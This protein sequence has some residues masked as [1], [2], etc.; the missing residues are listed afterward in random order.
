MKNIICRYIY[1]YY[2][3]NMSPLRINK[4]EWNKM[5]GMQNA[6][7]RWY[8]REMYYFLSYDQNFSCFF[9]SFRRR[10][11]DERKQKIK[12]NGLVGETVCGARACG[13]VG[14]G[15]GLNHQRLTVLWKTRQRPRGNRIYRRTSEGGK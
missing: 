9:W 7:T 6:G 2:T 1:M 14:G 10:Q 8:P 3:Y 12:I 4:T 11:T 5:F 15:G 13:V